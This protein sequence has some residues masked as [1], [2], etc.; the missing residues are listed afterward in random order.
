MVVQPKEQLVAQESCLVV[1]VCQAL[2]VAQPM[3]QVLVFVLARLEFG[4]RQLD[5]DQFVFVVNIQIHD[6][7]YIWFCHSM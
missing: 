2:E 7:V 1:A 4:L 6:L 5:F 3:F